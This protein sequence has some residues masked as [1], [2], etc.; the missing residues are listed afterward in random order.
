[1]SYS[2][3]PEWIKRLCCVKRSIWEIK[4]KCGHKWQQIDTKDKFRTLYKMHNN[5]PLQSCVH[6]RG[7]KTS[8]WAAGGFRQGEGEDAVIPYQSARLSVL[9][10]HARPPL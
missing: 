8:S 1:M 4:S 10:T 5:L 2:Y 7:S 9:H 3:N 6:G